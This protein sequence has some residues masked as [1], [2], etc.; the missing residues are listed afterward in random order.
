MAYKYKLYWSQESLENLEDILFYLNSKWTLREV[1]NFKKLLSKQIEII[2]TFPEIFPISVIQ[3]RLR[4]AVLSKQT[5]VFYEVS[6]DRIT[7]VYLFV[8]KKNPNQIK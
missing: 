7:I 1:D 2:L 3:P 8:V 6:E 5:I 4:K